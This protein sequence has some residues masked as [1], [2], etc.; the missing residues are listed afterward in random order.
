M[1]AFS[2]R[3]LRLFYK[4]VPCQLRITGKIPAID[5]MRTKFD[6]AIYVEKLPAALDA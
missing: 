5:A 6:A 2:G 4:Q 3:H 1:P